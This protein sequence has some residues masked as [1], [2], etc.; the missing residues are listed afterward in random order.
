MKRLL[1]GT[2][3]AVLVLGLASQAPADNLTVRL[4]GTACLDNTA[5]D[6]N[7]ALGVVVFTTS[8]G[9]ITVTGVGT[10]A[11]ANTPLGLD[12]GYVVNASL[13]SSAGTDTIEVSENFLS[14]LGQLSVWTGNIGGTNDNTTTTAQAWADAGNTLFA[15]TTSLC[16]PLSSGASNFGASCTSGSFNDNSFSLSELVTI[17]RGDGHATASGDF[18]LTEVPEPGALLLV[19]SALAGIGLASV[20]SLR[21]RFRRTTA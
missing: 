10:G 11:P 20:G 3:I 1:L 5:C 15:H 19:G 13:G 6:S 9:T 18:G 14:T 8:V 4:D 17:L 16:G 7:A 21:R 2:A 12:L